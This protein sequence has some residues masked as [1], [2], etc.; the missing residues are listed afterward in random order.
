MLLA[1]IQELGIR[2]EP[3]RQFLE[4]E[5]VEIH[6]SAAAPGSI[7]WARGAFGPA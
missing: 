3:E 6:E 4:F 5:Q 2:A 1:Q 7:S